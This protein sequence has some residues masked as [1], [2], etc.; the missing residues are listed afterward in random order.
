MCFSL[1]CSD[2]AHTYE[3]SIFFCTVA[4]IRELRI[5][6]IHIGELESALVNDLRFSKYVHTLINGMGEYLYAY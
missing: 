1:L 6:H 3:R 2:D 5:L 4:C